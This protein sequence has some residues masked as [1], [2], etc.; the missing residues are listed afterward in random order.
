MSI[1]REYSLTSCNGH[2]LFVMMSNGSRAKSAASPHRAVARHHAR[3]EQARGPPSHRGAASPSVAARDR[4]RGAHRPITGAPG[5][6][7]RLW[8][9][10]PLQRSFS[11]AVRSSARRVAALEQV[12]RGVG[13]SRRDRPVAS[14]SSTLRVACHSR[15]PAAARN[16]RHRICYRQPI[17][18]IS[19]AGWRA[20]HSLGRTRRWQCAARN[21]PLSKAVSLAGDHRAAAACV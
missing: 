17:R 11:D 1:H 4:Q 12:G 19:E 21:R 2:V 15:I 5:V 6:G 18:P 8:Q 16:R 14:L 10:A 3:G 20:G 13:T 7:H 9:C